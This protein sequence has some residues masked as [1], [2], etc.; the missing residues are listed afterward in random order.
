MVEFVFLGVVL[1]VPLVYLVITVARI[2]AGSLAVE[3]AAR[4]G[5]RAFVTAP[6]AR[7]GEVRASA[8]VSLAYDDQ[9]FGPPAPGQLAIT[10]N[11]GSCL[12]PGARV[13]VR[14]ELVVVLPGVPRFL[15][16]VIPVSVTLGATHVASVDE[17]ARR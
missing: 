7:S 11:S 4:E 13:T 6:D 17:F 8:A 10:C 16:D 9:G 14:T 3:Q 15:S 2:Q 1:L 12:E 5:S